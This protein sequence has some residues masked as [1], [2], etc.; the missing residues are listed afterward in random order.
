MEQKESGRIDR[1]CGNRA[2]RG[3][4]REEE[5]APKAGGA[6]AGAGMGGQDCKGRLLSQPEQGR[7]LA[8][9]FFVYFFPAILLFSVQLLRVGKIRLEFIS[10]NRRKPVRLELIGLRLISRPLLTWDDFL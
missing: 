10:H 9:G 8:W 3:S 5:S 7:G 2:W 4:G 6:R 1:E